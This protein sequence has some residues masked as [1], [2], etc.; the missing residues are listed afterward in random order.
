MKVA[1]IGGGS[2]YTP[3]LMNGFLTI[4]SALNVAEVALVDTDEGARKLDA[5]AGLARRMVAA[6]GSPIQV[7][8]T[9]QLD[10]G[11][12]G[13]QVVINQ[14]R[15]GGFEARANDER[16]PLEFGLVGQETT[17]VGG[18][19]KAL[20][21]L[22]VLDRIVESVRRNSDDAWIIN[23]TNP[24][25]LNTEYLCNTIGYP[26]AIGLCNVPIEF[27]LRAAEILAC[28]RDE[29]FLR[30]YGLNHLSWVAGVLQ[31]GTDRTEEFWRTFSIQMSN[32]PDVEYQ[33]G[34][35]EMLRLLPNPYLEYF[36][37]TDT[38]LRQQ[39]S[40]R[41]NGGTR[42]EQIM[43]LEPQ[44]LDMYR[45]PTRTTIPDELSQR[46]GFMYSTVAVELLRDLLTDA[47]TTHIV[48]TLNRGAVPNLP[49]DFVL[50]IPAKIGIE[51]PRTSF[52]CEAHEATIG[53][54]Q[55]IKQFERLTIAAHREGS[56]ARVKQ[57]LLTHPLGPPERSLNEV[58]EALL[59]ANLPY[60]PA[61]RRGGL[62][63][64]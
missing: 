41:E 50:E 30:Y 7:T 46:G 48:N 24:A 40:D 63:N 38:V 20:R 6:A 44:L 37:N 52:V 2:T 42:A 8:T 54:I 45:D 11:V 23:F 17:G 4:G 64:G 14:F 35:L 12:A 36:Y 22:P 25:G 53:L 57:A 62:R 34:F 55:T 5:V 15:V 28:D 29:V 39:L 49:D 13:S 19:M 51:G 58:W 60:L 10:A 1:V 9:T 33:P 32:N 31:N 61:F 18:M 56:E 47:G 43:R 3:E 21:T 59:E 16:I 27:V 26:K